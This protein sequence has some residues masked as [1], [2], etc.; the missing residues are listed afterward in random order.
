MPLLPNNTQPRKRTRSLILFGFLLV[1]TLCL[2]W[3]FTHRYDVLDWWRLRNY[4][5][6]TPIQQ[7]ADQTTMTE[8]GRTLFYVNQPVIQNKPD[9][10]KTC[11]KGG[12]EQTIVLGC[13]RGGERGIFLLKVDDARLNGVVQVTAAHEM[14]HVAYERLSDKDRIKVDAM[15]MDYYKNQLTDARIKK[16]IAAYK[17]SE[18][19]DVVNEMHSIFGT[20]ITSLPAP[21]EAYYTQYFVSRKVVAG[22][23][24]QYQREFTARQE[25]ITAYDT[26][27]NELKTRIDAKQAGLK[28]QEADLQARQAQLATLRTSNVT[29]YN[30]AV[31]SYNAVV[32]SYNA[33]IASV[34]VLIGQYNQL[35]AQRN[36]VALEQDVLVQ[37]LST[38]AQPIGE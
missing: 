33:E 14:L 7:L 28:T 37:E 6:P 13:Y 5:A 2:W 31:P 35:V 10:A 36:A 26:E 1:W 12:G 27:L 17:I 15:L 24:N 11:P 29:A 30:A 16:V 25:K 20:E 19:N 23:A 3:A 4:Q 22:F 18:P 8:Y 34:R 32:D 9:F 21:L 38:D